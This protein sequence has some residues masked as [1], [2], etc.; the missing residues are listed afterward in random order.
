MIR[1][2]VTNP[3]KTK[4]LERIVP[5]AFNSELNEKHPHISHKPQFLQNGF[6]VPKRMLSTESKINSKFV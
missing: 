6:G 3:Q 2:L 4:L 5:I 1:L